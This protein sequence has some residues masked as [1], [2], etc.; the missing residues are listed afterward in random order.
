MLLLLL[1]L[2][3]VPSIT[4]QYTPPTWPQ[5]IDDQAYVQAEGVAGDLLSQRND[6]IQQTV[7]PGVHRYNC[8]WASYE[9]SNIPSSKAPIACPENYDLV[10]PDIG[11]LKANGGLYFRFRCIFRLLIQ[12]QLSYLQEDARLGWQ[13]SAVIWCAPPIYRNPACLGQPSGG[14]ESAPANITPAFT[15]YAQIQ[16][17]QQLNVQ[18]FVEAQHASVVEAS[19]G[20]AGAESALDALGCSCAP[21]PEFV[22]DFQDFVTVLLD[23]LP[24]GDARLQHVT[25]WNEVSY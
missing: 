10:P 3:I 17:G 14:I 9:D 6:F 23:W 25:V 20:T 4:E 16:T 18:A 11:G 22:P 8:L 7:A 12:Q 13:S 21:A 1:L 15:E 5:G 19:N 24:Q 2:K